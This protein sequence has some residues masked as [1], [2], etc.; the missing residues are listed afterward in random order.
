[1]RNR[2][3]WN[4]KNLQRYFTRRVFT[5][6]RWVGSQ[7]ITFISAKSAM[8]R[9]TPDQIWPCWNMFKL[10]KGF[11]GLNAAQF[12][13]FNNHRAT[14]GHQYKL[15]IKRI[16]NRVTRN[17]VFSRC[18]CVWNLL[19]DTYLRTNLCATFKQYLSSFDF[20]LYIRG[21]A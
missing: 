3:K 11:S 12:I 13:T 15:Y 1:M 10:C 7:L 8:S 5:K 19:P 20:S 2:G 21:R 9:T 16:C 6:L 17:F 14:R 4:Q 18:A